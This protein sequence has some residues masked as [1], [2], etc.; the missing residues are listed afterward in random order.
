MTLRPN[1]AF[2][3]ARLL[4][5]STAAVRRRL[6]LPPGSRPWQKRTGRCWRRDRPGSSRTRLASRTQRASFQCNEF[7]PIYPFRGRPRSLM[8]GPLQVLHNREEA[9]AMNH[10]QFEEP[11]TLLVELGFPARIENVLEA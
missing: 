11:V 1:L 3:E 2:R 8:L 6:P 10:R 5:G 7:T 4:H 9:Q